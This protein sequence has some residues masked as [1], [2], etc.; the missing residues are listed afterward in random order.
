MRDRQ[1]SPLRP[2]RRIFTGLVAVFLAFAPFGASA[3]S[4]THTLQGLFC[5]TADQI[6][7]AL[8]HMRRGVSPRAAVALT[9]QATVACTFV[10]LL[11][12]VVERPAVIAEM[13]GSPRMFKY[14]GT[15]VGVVAGGAT[16]PVTPPVRIFFAIPERLDDARVEGRA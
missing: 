3:G 1:V 11:H 12:Y 4:R 8:A 14:E 6:D 9:N 10:D 15:L 7:E 16:R 2:R 13:R 5:N